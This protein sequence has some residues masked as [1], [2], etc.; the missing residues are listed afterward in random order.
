MEQVGLVV[1]VKDDKAVVAVQRHDVCAK[2]GGCGAA[3]SGSGETHL[4]AL[5]KVNAA[6]GQTVMISSDTA[7]VLK[8]SFMV[9]MVPLL[10]LLAGLYIG[11][12]LDGILGYVARL[13]IILGITLLLISYLLV[14]I[15]D[16]K[17]SRRRILATVI[18][19][20]HDEPYTGP[21][22]EKC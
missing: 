7:Q 10:F 9:Y 4:E 20:L 17:L 19:I 8:A 11:Q 3:V 13:D 2:C 1:E 21:E 16:R 6:V 5:N 14:R 22:D 12:Q 15:Y 18:E